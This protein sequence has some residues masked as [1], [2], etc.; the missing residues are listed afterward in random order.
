MIFILRKHLKDSI[1]WRTQMGGEIALEIPTPEGD[2]CT[3]GGGLAFCLGASFPMLILTQKTVMTVMASVAVSVWAIVPVFSEEE[4]SVGSIDFEQGRIFW[5]F[6][7]VKKLALPPV[8]V[9]L[10]VKSTR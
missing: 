1:L 6:Q 9:F 4:L 10:G 7:P 2:P 8:P 5:S 3:H